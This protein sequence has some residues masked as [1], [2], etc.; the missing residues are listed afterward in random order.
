M[1]AKKFSMGEA[2][3]FGWRTLKSN[4]GFFIVLLLAVALINGVPDYIANLIHEEA[5]TASFLISVGSWVLSIIVQMGLV[6]IA[7]R[8]CDNE[9]ATLGDL[10]SC[11]GFFFKYL[12][13]SIL[14]ALIVLVGLILLIVPGI[15]WGIKFMFYA[16][17]IIDKGMGPIES[18]KRSSAITRGTKWDLFLF[19]LLLFLINILGALCLIIGLFAT[20]PTTMVAFAYVYRRLLGQAQGLP[21]SQA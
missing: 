1:A 5:P 7:L 20:A 12:F 13:A 17:L 2:L 11:V 15:I 6:R 9:K 4:L 3:R 19:I 10:F 8:F 14:Y 18:L 21:V 16:Y